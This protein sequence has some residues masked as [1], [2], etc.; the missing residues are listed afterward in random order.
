MAYDQPLIVGLNKYSHDASVCIIGANDGKV[1]YAQ[2]KERITRQ[3]H[4]GGAVGDNLRHGLEAIGA[5]LEDIHTVVSNNHHFRVTPF[6]KR[7]PFYVPLQYVPPDYLDDANLVPT[8]KNHLELSHHLAHAYSVACSAPFK[9]GLI[10]VMDGMGESYKSMAE[11]IAGM[12]ESSGDYMHDLRLIRSLDE[13]SQS[14]FVGKPRSLFPG[15]G[16]REAESAYTF[17]PDRGIVPVFK[18]WSRER[19][20]RAL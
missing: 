4:D 9:S 7:I 14:K 19:S 13:E 6:E 16:Y 17:D 2:A 1:L 3:K 11:D 12:E 8:A 18:R 5:S 20:P 10:L 15:S